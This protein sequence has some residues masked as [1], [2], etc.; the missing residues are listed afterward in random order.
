MA[1]FF[2]KLR[3]ITS[4]LFQVGKAGPNLKSNG[5]ALE[6]RNNADTAYTVHR[7]DQPAGDNDGVDRQTFYNNFAN[8][9]DPYVY[10]YGDFSVFGGT[11]GSP[12]NAN[13]IQY[14]RVWLPKGRVITK[15]RTF[16]VSGANGTRQIQ[17][18]L[19][20]QATPT[21]IT[22][23]P[24]SKVASTAA[25]AVPNAT[26]GYY[27]VSLSASYTVANSGFYWLAIQFDNSAIVTALSVVY[28]ANTVNRREETP[29]TF[30]LSATAGATTQP[31]SAIILC[32]AVE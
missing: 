15:M 5:T 9:N 7:L 3:G 19:Y 25:T 12:Q 28:R 31:Q 30:T 13:E 1:G 29:G 8:P 22:G 24:N 27:D 18:G 20:D 23:T 4:N 32:A 17:F 10:I 14:T 21:S 2:A 6:S 11:S 16:I 26:T